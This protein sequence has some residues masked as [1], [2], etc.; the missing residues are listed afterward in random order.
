MTDDLASGATRSAPSRL[1]ASD[2][3]LAYGAARVVH[4]VSIEVPPSSVTAIVGPNGC[5]K[6]TLLRGLARLHAPSQGTVLLDGRDIHERSTKDVARE[7]GILPQSPVAPGGITVRD[8]VGRGRTPHLRAL[9][10]WGDQDTSAVNDAL[11][12]TGL[13]G[14]AERAVDSLSGGQ[15]Q[16]AWIAL[17]LA[18]QTELLLLDEPTTFLDI[19]HQYEV[20]DLLHG[21]AAEGRTVVVV[22]HDL[23][24]AAR[25]ADHLVLMSAGLILSRGEPG[26]VLTADRVSAAFGLPVTVVPDPVTGTPLIVPTGTPVGRS[27]T[28]APASGMKESVHDHEIH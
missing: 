7:L 8:L 24:Q 6:S 23:A 14:L 26:E 18:Q 28:P 19:A 20:L 13:F 10:P 4:N 22:L 21:L 9:R 17:A 2:L 12:A 11:R 27:Y 15:R 3:T 1:S 5:G 25:Y 16:R